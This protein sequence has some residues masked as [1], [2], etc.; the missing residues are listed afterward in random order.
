M[1]EE[2]FKCDL[3]PAVQFPENNSPYL[4][5]LLRVVL[6]N[7]L[8]EHHHAFGKNIRGK[9]YSYERQNSTLL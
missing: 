8:S 4:A 3:L 1:C 9:H 6:R 2:E 5:L 7:I